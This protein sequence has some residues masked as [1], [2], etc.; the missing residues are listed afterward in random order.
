MLTGC[1]ILVTGCTGEVARGISEALSPHN[2]VWGAA[3]FTNLEA[4]RKLEDK[5]VK[6]FVWA[7]GEGD[8]RSLPDDFD[9]VIHSA[10]AIFETK[11]DYDASIRENAEGVGLLMHH[12]KNAKAFLHVSALQ[13]YKAIADKARPRKE[14]EPLGS[15]PAYAPSYGI[16]K[17]AAEAVVRTMCR[18]HDLPTTIGRLGANYGVGCGG[19]AEFTLRDMLAGKTLIVPP[20]G[21][22]WLGL[23]NNG[24]IIDQ[25]EPLL[26]AATVPA[27]IVNWVADEGVEYRELIDYIAEVAGIVPTLEEREGAGPVGGVGDPTKRISITGPCKHSWRENIREMIWRNHPELSRP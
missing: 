27:T 17:L 15:H 5:G 12:V 8:F 13:I 2:D 21:T 19:V 25:L 24:D 22:S 6:T 16:G 4:K 3:R 23:V 20:R 9:Y 26:Q 10:A 1:K 18:I 7:L 14:N 11:D